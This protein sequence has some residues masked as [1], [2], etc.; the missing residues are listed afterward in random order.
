[1][2][3]SQIDASI[4]AEGLGLALPLLQE[5]MRAGKIT[6]LCRARDRRRQRPASPDLLLRTPAISRR[7][8]RNRRDHSALGAS[9]S[10]IRRCR[11]QCASPAD[12][13]SAMRRAEPRNGAALSLKDRRGRNRRLSAA[14][15]LP[16]TLTRLLPFRCL[17]LSDLPADLP[18][19]CLSG[20]AVERLAVERIAVQLERLLRLPLSLFLQLR[21]AFALA[22]ASFSAFF[23]AFR[24]ALAFRRAFSARASARCFLR[25]FSQAAHLQPIGFR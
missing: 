13:T 21:F 5:E 15:F 6:S 12:E 25:F 17:P 23:S 11:N 3:P 14:D 18:C 10:A 4:V 7:G 22:L 20:L 1:M 16:A 8:R 9:T 2:A 19:T 24:S